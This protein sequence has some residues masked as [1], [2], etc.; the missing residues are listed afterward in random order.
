MKTEIFYSDDDGMSIESA[1]KVLNANNS[2]DGVDAEYRYI[3]KK[4]GKKSIHWNF[5]SQEIIRHNQRNYDLIVLSDKKGN[6]INLYFDIT[7]F[8]GKIFC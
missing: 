1:I 7:D 4:Y 5:I 2:F 3:E 6:I 8:Y